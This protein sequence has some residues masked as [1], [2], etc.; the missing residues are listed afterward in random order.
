MQCVNDVE[1]VDYRRFK[2]NHQYRH[3][4]GNNGWPIVGDLPS[5][6]SDLYKLADSHYEK[7]GSISKLNLVMQKGVLALG[8]DL[9]QQILLD[10]NQDFSPKM[11]YRRS[12][13]PFFGEGLLLHDFDEHRFQRRILQSGFKTPAMKGYVDLMNPILQQG[14]A[15]WDTIDDFHFFPHIKSLLLKVALNVFYGVDED[16]AT[17]KALSQA[18]LNCLE[19]QM[20]IFMIDKPGF[21]YHIGMQG[22]QFLRD[23][24][25]K[26]IPQRRSEDGQDMLSYMCKEKKEDGSFFGDEEILDHA[27]FLLFAAHD[28]TTSTLNHLIYYLAKE[29]QWQQRLRDESLALNKAALDYEDLAALP[30]L[31]MVF[32]ESQRLHPSVS[33]L[34]RRTTRQVMLDGHLIPPHTLIFQVPAFNNRF[35][36]YWSNADSFDPERFSPE[37]AEH[38]S[39]PFAYMPFGGGAHKCIG[40]HFAQMQS[41]LFC[42]QFLQ[43]YSVSLLPNYRAK[44]QH[45]PMP[46]LRDDLPLSLRRL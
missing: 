41:K 16:E 29:P 15:S 13:K 36:K 32:N 25:Q 12:L 5:A 40:M 6:L 17:A 7:H 30:E 28:T 27:G 24:I 21:K 2:D 43:H 38:K 3:I 45:L 18:F 22:R 42:H 33:I 34:M 26:L 14:I 46:K 23:Y 35:K 1:E 10:R 39:H 4:P 9:S 11:G 31:E 19:G 20:G 37:R 44:F 8:P